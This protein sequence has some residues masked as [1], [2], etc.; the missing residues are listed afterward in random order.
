M[1]PDKRDSTGGTRDDISSEHEDSLGNGDDRLPALAGD[2]IV[3][4]SSRRRGLAPASGNHR[5]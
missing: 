4:R 1:I 3:R 2:R 5:P